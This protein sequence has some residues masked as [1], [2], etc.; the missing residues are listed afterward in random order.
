M[1]NEKTFM[2]DAADPVGSKCQRPFV[3]GVAQLRG[4]KGSAVKPCNVK[5]RL[6]NGSSAAAT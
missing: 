3:A 6:E 1:F 5:V 4:G 2:S